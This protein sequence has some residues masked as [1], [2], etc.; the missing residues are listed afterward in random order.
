LIIL[1]NEKVN[2]VTALGKA[3]GN[4]PKVSAACGFRYL[5]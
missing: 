2:P 1:K 3:S 5:L 4:L